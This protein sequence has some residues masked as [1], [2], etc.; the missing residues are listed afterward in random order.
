M[1]KGVL[2]V[3]CETYLLG[4]A[5]SY[6]EYY[7]ED[8]AYLNASIEGGTHHLEHRA[9]LTQSFL[10]SLVNEAPELKEAFSRIIDRNRA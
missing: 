3:L 7:E 2:G 10:E 6:L 9:I 5:Q 8:I 4:L 1:T